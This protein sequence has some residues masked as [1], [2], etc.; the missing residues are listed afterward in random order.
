[1]DDI[2]HVGDSVTVATGSVTEG[3]H[4]ELVETKANAVFI[5][6]LEYCILQMLSS[7]LTSYFSEFSEKEIVTLKRED[8]AEILKTNRFLDWL[9]E[10][11]YDM[12]KERDIMFSDLPPEKM[13]REL[14]KIWPKGSH[15][16]SLF[17]MKIPK[18]GQLKLEGN[19]IV[20]EHDLFSVSF[21]CYFS[22]SDPSLPQGF[23]EYYMGIPK[24]DGKH[25]A[26]Q[27]SVTITVDF[28]YRAMLLNK[29]R[30]YYY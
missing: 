4:I 1:M 24:D 21:E 15:S 6:L 14:L 12:E 20:I 22:A 29:W 10:V 3:Y 27:Y 2:D 26:C 23:S 8:V 16:Y 7:H 18:G 19:T 5:E 28:K 30:K 9:S 13:I 17:E 25:R 11:K